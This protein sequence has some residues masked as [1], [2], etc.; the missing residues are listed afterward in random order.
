M[1]GDID[2][3][4]VEF[5][6]PEGDFASKL[7][8]ELEGGFHEGQVKFACNVVNIDFVE[9]FLIVDVVVLQ[10]LSKLVLFGLKLRRPY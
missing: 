4:I 3:D 7:F 10:I 6:L 1:I 2:T 5:I 9:F 8:S